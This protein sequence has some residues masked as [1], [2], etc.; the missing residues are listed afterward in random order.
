M[1]LTAPEVVGRLDDIRTVTG[2]SVRP[3]VARVPDGDYRP[4]SPEAAAV[5]VLP[6]A[7]LTDPD[8]YEHEFRTHP[9][10]GEALVHYFHVDGHTVWGATGRIL[11]QLLELAT[12][13]RAP[14][15]ED[16]H[17]DGDVA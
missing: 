4:T 12:D 16:S 11:V 10:Y 1:S 8:N 6:V 5:V 13:W 9:D 2:Y 17:A 7:G 15:H 3:F 14:A